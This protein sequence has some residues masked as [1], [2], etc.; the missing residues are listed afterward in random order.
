MKIRLFVV[1]IFLCTAFPNKYVRAA[2][3]TPEDY[4]VLI[5]EE[6]PQYKNWLNCSLELFIKLYGIEDTQNAYLYNVVTANG[7]I[8]GY[9]IVRESDN[10]LLEY[11]KNENPYMVAQEKYSIEG[12]SLYIY[13][14]YE[15]KNDEDI[16]SLNASGELVDIEAYDSIIAEDNKISTYGYVS[17]SISPQLQNSNNCIVA[18]ISNLIWY[19][20]KNGYSSLIKDKTFDGHSSKTVTKVWT[21]YN[22]YICKVR[23]K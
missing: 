14:N 4:I 20:G 11:S 7:D 15:I 1:L 12:Q 2:S 23:V 18:A 5:V 13:G 22:D 9:I 8:D 17:G 3:S 10:L 19:Y 16:Y 21:K 6:E